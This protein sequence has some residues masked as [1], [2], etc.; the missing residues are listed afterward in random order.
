MLDFYN[1]HTFFSTLALGLI[2]FY[3]KELK[4][5]KGADEDWEE[6][7]KERDSEN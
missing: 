6:I 4:E 5:K 7:K 3:F 1:E 2:Y